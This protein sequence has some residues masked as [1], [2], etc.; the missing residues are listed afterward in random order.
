[1]A[2]RRKH[3]DAAKRTERH[4]D[5]VDLVHEVRRSCL[6]AQL[7]IEQV[8]AIVGQS[9]LDERLTVLVY[10]SERS[11]NEA[12]EAVQLALAALK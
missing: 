11:T 12:L 7:L 10:A 9:R 4:I 8:V 1:M 6:L 2:N 3:R 5:A